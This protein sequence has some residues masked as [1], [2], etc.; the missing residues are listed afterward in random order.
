VGNE[1]PTAL[2]SN[3]AES[4]RLFGNPR[5]SLRQMIEVIAGWVKAGGKTLDKPT[6]FQEREGQF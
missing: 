2:L 6:H 5:V 3:A 4:H 1:E